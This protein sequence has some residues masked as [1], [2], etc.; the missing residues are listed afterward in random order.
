MQVHFRSGYK[1]RWKSGRW[2]LTAN[3][4]GENG[5]ADT[6]G[7]TVRHRPLLRAAARARVFVLGAYK[8]SVNITG[9]RTGGKLKD[10]TCERNASCEK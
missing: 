5:H 9:W 6:I 1:S 7:G 2:R 4:K 3:N 10:F 8:I